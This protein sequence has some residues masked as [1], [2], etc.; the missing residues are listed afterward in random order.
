[1]S[2]IP[3]SLSNQKRTPT[4]SSIT[5]VSHVHPHTLLSLPV[6]RLSSCPLIQSPKTPL[7]L[8]SLLHH[9]FLPLGWISLI[10]VRRVLFIPFLSGYHHFS[11]PLKLKK[12]KRLIFTVSNVFH[13]ILPWI[14]SSQNFISPMSLKTTLVKVIQHCEIQGFFFFFFNPDLI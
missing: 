5:S 7:I 9:H 1:M 13:P 3:I 12:K 10:S 6:L 8:P 11:S 2:L 4:S 14:Y